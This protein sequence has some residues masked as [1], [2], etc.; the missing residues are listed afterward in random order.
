MTQ[1]VGELT[2]S[3]SQDFVFDV[4]GMHCAACS[5]RIERVLNGKDGIEARVNLTLERADV[6][7]WGG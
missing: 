7:V 3:P 1:A 4:S 6:R 5:A 2:K